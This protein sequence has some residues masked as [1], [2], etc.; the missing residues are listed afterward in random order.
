MIDINQRG[1]I[2]RGVERRENRKKKV[3][4]K[5]HMFDGAN[6]NLFRQFIFDFETDN[7]R[8]CVHLSLYLPP[9]LPRTRKE[10]AASPWLG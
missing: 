5:D 6:D 10:I 4:P 8:S 1:K 3:M 7:I 2:E 9:S